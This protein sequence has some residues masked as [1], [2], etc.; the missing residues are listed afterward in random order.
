MKKEQWEKEFDKLFGYEIKEVQKEYPNYLS[1]KPDIKQ[2][3]KS[4][5]KAKSIKL[6]KERS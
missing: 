2:F 6:L 5:L 4:L 1:H 3:I